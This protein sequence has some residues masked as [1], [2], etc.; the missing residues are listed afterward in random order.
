MCI[1]GF[2][3]LGL[4]PS[5][6]TYKTQR[7]PPKDPF[8]EMSHATSS[9]EDD[10]E[11]HANDL[12]SHKDIDDSL[13]DEASISPVSPVSDRP[14]W[15]QNEDDQLRRV[16]EMGAATQDDAKRRRKLIL[17]PK[18]QER[19]VQCVHH[20]VNHFCCHLIIL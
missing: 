19:D 17:V 8:Q 20:L 2:I 16:L 9:W 7:Y 4:K 18:P 3:V 1:L 15:Y 6:S 10:K 14:T 13:H 12:G 11:T 5:C